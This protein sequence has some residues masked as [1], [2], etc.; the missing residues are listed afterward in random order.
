MIDFYI[1]YEDLVVAAH[2][3][4]RV[5]I[6]LLGFVILCAIFQVYGRNAYKTSLGF[7]F[8]LVHGFVGFVH[9]GCALVD[10]VRVH[11]HSTNFLGSS[12]VRMFMMYVSTC[13]LFGSW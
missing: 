13:S 5:T 9:K 1:Y 8:Q 6:S 2:Y 11:H 12:S 4:S 10:L 7:Y 3:L